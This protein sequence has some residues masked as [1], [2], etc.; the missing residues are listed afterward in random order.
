MSSFSSS[1]SVGLG[2]ELRSVKLAGASDSYGGNTFGQC[3]TAVL[4]EAIVAAQLEFCVT[5]LTYRTAMQA[6]HRVVALS[7]A[8]A[9][10]GGVCADVAPSEASW[11]TWLGLSPRTS[12]VA[13]AAPG[14]LVVWGGAFGR[15]PRGV[16][17]VPDSATRVAVGD[18]V[19]AA[20]VADGSVYAFSPGEGP[21]QRLAIPSQAAD[22]ATRGA[23]REVVV[24]DRAGKVHVSRR[25]ND[26][27]FCPAEVLQGALKSVRA[28][29][30]DCGEQHCIAVSS[31][32]RAVAWGAS[33]SHG[34]LGNGLVGA[35]PQGL[36]SEV[37]AFVQLPESVKVVDAACGDRHS[38]FLDKHGVLYAVG[39]DHWAQLGISA[40][41]WLK[42]HGE[43][44]GL[45]QRSTLL[46]DLAV[47][48]IACGGQHTVVA[49]RDGTVFSFGFNQFGQLGHHNFSSFAPPSPISDFHLRARDVKAGRNN[50]CVLTES[51]QMKCIGANEHGQLG[52][53]SLQPSMLWKRIRQMTSSGSKAT[54]APSAIALSGDVCAA[55]VPVEEYRA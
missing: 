53:G 2:W 25:R 31:D 55:I 44:T 51:G 15:V 16:H 17:G 52:N 40:E 43:P 48:G 34:Q 47:A 28:V 9:C 8:A 23:V 29:K 10:T 1:S 12:E 11:W 20:V 30:V 6:L 39:D 19:G 36:P 45:V 50:T 24:L 5:S 18:S 33:N 27:V 42:G 37:P 26:G 7:A 13:A 4:P 14:R 21:A 46:A 35:C 3:D 54:L 49:V 22:V 38:I 32:G 41:P